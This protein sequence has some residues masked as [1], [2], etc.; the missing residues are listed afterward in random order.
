MEIEYNVSRKGKKDKIKIVIPQIERGEYYIIGMENNQIRYSFGD[1]SLVKKL[2]SS[3]KESTI[4][5]IDEEV[6]KNN[7]KRIKEI[8]DYIKQ[9]YF[10]DL[11]KDSFE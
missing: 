7:F 11:D 10:I 4:I 8:T 2:F 9:E 5:S 3:D 1:Y 6:A